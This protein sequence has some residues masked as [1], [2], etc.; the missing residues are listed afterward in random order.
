VTARRAFDVLVGGALLAAVAVPCVVVAILVCATSP[1]PVLY[2]QTRIGRGG[3]PFVFYK[4]RTMRAEAGGPAVT[5]DGDPRVTPVGRVLRR[6]KL[7]ELPQ[8][9]NVVRGDMAVIGPRPEVPRFVARYGP[10]ERGILAATPGLAG[11]AQ[12]AFPHEA[13]LLRGRPDAERYYVEELLPRKVAADL[14]YERVRTLRS[15]LALLLRIAGLIAG[16][17]SD[18]AAALA[19]ASAPEDGGRAA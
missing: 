12:L 19:A 18:V 2:R 10:A 1:G 16:R 14:A 6:W 17:R 4:F 15:D 8:L 5:A 3:R 11:M 13:V 9:W 7:D